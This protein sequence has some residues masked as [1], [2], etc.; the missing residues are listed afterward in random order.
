M[1]ERNKPKSAETSWN[2]TSRTS[3]MMEELCQKGP[4]VVARKSSSF[5]YHCH[6]QS[7]KPSAEHSHGPLL[8]LN[9]FAHKSRTTF[10][11]VFFMR[12]HSFFS[13]R[14]RPDL[15]RC[16]SPWTMGRGLWKVGPCLVLQFSLNFTIKKK[17]LRHIK[18]SVN[19]W[20]TKYWWNQ[21][22]IVQFCCTLRDEHFKP[23]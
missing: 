10:F 14:G 17:I 22:L 3:P 21:K 7:W 13:M 15:K 12:G 11:L 8:C 19:A 2:M 4:R 23:T 18:M 9:A 1:W 6:F 16:Q 5:N 20:S